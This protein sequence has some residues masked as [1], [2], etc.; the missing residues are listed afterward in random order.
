M[1]VESLAKLVPSGLAIRR[2]EMGGDFAAANSSNLNAN[3]FK[4]T[5]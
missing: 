4:W 3:I 1:L 5:K 2:I